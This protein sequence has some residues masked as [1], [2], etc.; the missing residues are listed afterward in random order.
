MSQSSRC[1]LARLSRSRAPPSF[2][3]LSRGG[4]ASGPQPR[5][6]SPSSAA[7]RPVGHRRTLPTR[8]VSLSP[9]ATQDL[10]AVGA[11]SAGR[12]GRLLL[13]LPAAG[14]ADEPLGLHARTSRRSRGTGPTSSSSPTTT[15]TS[16]RQLRTLSIPVLLEP[17][18]ANL[19]GV[20]AEIGQIAHATGHAAARRPR[21]V[22]SMRSQIAAIV[23]LRCRGRTAA[24]RLQRA[25]PGRTTPRPR[26][27]S[28]GS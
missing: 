18:A 6:R 26:G 4:P 21:V 10:Y 9:S 13:D 5:S 19:A 25:R 17:A 15:T 1:Q 24:D 20:Y 8:I 2:A 11:G 22:A 23:A 7:E 16:S 14:A 28:S 12:R 27:P 3:L